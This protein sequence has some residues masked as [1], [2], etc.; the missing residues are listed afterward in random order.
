MTVW[1]FKFFCSFI[2]T[3]HLSL[4][5]VSVSKIRW[6]V[7][8]FRLLRLLYP[9][10]KSQAN[11]SGIRHIPPEPWIPLKSNWVFSIGMCHRT[12]VKNCIVTLMNKFTCLAHLLK[13]HLIELFMYKVCMH[14][15]AASVSMLN[16]WKVFNSSFC[17]LSFNSRIFQFYTLYLWGVI[18]AKFV[19][20][21]WNLNSTRKTL[22]NCNTYSANVHF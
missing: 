4:Y 3:W 9:Y 14:M 5:M 6:L 13:E 19:I 7:V 18:F 22:L 8:I 16:K 20:G 11:F 2:C 17:N 10:R 12:D 15:G 1:L 21:Y